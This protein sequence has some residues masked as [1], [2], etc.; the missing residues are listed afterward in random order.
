LAN[1]SRLAQRANEPANGDSCRSLHEEK[2]FQDRVLI[3]ATRPYEWAPREIW[4]TD[5]V[6]KGI[7]LKFPLSTRPRSNVALNVSRRWDELGIK[8]TARFIGRPE[9]IFKN[10]WQDEEIVAAR[11]LKVLP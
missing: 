6:G 10:W 11:D 9:G 7:P 8:P 1:Q 4:A 3:D 5:G 2:G